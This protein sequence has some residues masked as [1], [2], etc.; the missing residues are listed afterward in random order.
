MQKTAL[1]D[2]LEGADAAELTKRV[3]RWKVA[4]TPASTDAVPQALQDLKARLESL[5]NANHVMLFMKG[6]PDAPKCKFSR[7]T[8]ELLQEAGATFGSFDILSSEA[9]RQGL[10]EWANWP[11]YPQLYVD[12]QLVGGLDIMK[13]MQ[14][15]GELRALLL[16]HD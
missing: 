13:E 16:G 1:L 15:A 14:E 12:G 5:I 4:A 7:R 2:R 3:E 10:K 6:A 11:T 8:V 9:V